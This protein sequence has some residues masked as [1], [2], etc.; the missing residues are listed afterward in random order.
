MP[1]PLEVEL[2]LRAETDMPLRTLAEASRLDATDLGPADE[3]SEVDEY[4]DTTDGRLAAAG[5]ACRLRTRN[6]ATRISLKGPAQHAPGSS[7]HSRPEIEGPASTTA[8][9]E[10][11]PPSPALDRLLELSGGEPLVE[12]VT[13]R[14]LRTE[15]SVTVHGERAGMLTLDRVHVELSGIERGGFLAVELELE[16]LALDR[17]LDPAI[18]GRALL[19]VPGLVEEPQTKLERAIALLR[20][21]GA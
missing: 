15:R 11:W 2:K 4:L 20:R 19:A 10:A 17:G 1:D 5:W 7:L 6:G 14:Q 21:G 9:R 12:L 8:P 18:L 13:L 3:V 16:P